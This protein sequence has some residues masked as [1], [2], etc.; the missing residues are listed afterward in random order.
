MYTGPSAN[1][2]DIP[3]GNNPRGHPD[4]LFQRRHDGLN[5]G[6][7][8]FSGWL[9]QSL[10]V[11]MVF[12]QCV[13]FLAVIGAANGNY[14]LGPFSLMVFIIMHYFFSDTAKAD[15][16]LAVF[17]MVIGLIIE[18]LFLRTGVLNFVG[19]APSSEFAPL[20]V[21]V[22]WA[23]FALIM[24]GCLQWLQRHLIF[25]ALL[26]SSGGAVSYFAGI[27]LGAATTGSAMPIVL[28]VIAV[29]YALVTPVFLDAARRLS[30]AL[31]CARR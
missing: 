31:Q 30:D 29:T 15:Y 5:R 14:W 24:N 26:G 8:F 20:W 4:A 27:K 11:N 12:F 18:T 19:T 6:I 23:N 3:P 21:V 9:T 16:L 1:S 7:G 10:L 22:L 28:A 25:A 2:P 13:W 17:A